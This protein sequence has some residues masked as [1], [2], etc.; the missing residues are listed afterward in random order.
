VWLFSHGTFDTYK[1]QHRGCGLSRPHHPSYRLTNRFN[2]QLNTESG[3]TKYQNL[4]F[5]DDTTSWNYEVVSE[6]DA[7]FGVADSD[8][9]SLEHFFSRPIKITSLTWAVGSDLFYDFNPWTLYFSNPR[10]INRISNFHLLRCNLKVKFVINGNGFYFGRAIASYWPLRDM[11]NLTTNRNFFPIDIIGASQRPHVYID[12]ATSQGGVLKLPFCWYRNALSIPLQE[13]ERMGLMNLRSM[14]PLRHANSGTESISVSVFVWAEDVNLSIPTANEPGALVPQMGEQD[15]Y[16]TGPIS[17]PAGVI[18]RYAGML[19]NIPPIA[20][21]ARATQMAASTVSNI[22]QMFGYSR[23]AILSDI[24]PYRPT[25]VGNMANTNVP[26]SVTKLTLDAK[27]ELTVDPRVAGLGSADEMPILSIAMRETFL[28]SFEWPIAAAS[29]TLLWN[30]EV[31]P[32]LWAES[33]PEYHFPACAFATLP[34]K[35]WRGSMK[36][37][38][39]IVAS[40]YHRGR[41]KMTYDPSYPLTNEYNTNYTHVVDVSQDKDFTITVGWGATRSMLSYRVPYLSAIPYGTSALGGAPDEFGN[42]IVSV[43][44]VNELSTP[45]TNTDAVNVNVFVSMGEDFEVFEPSVDILQNAY[46]LPPSDEELLRQSQ[47]KN[48]FVEQM[49]EIPLTENSPPMDTSSVVTKAPTL[50]TA[51]ATLSVYF[52]DP[53]TSFRQC[54]KRYNYHSQW[55]PDTIGQVAY[56][57]SM[58]NFPLFRGY[59]SQGVWQTSTAERFNYVQTTL[60]NYVSTAYVVRRGGLRWKHVRIGGD[61]CVNDIF[62]AIR[63]DCGC[64]GNFTSITLD[65]PGAA[66]WDA[67][68]RQL[69][70]FLT[71]TWSG[72]HSTVVRNNATLEIELPWYY[73]DRFFPSKDVTSS[74]FSHRLEGTWKIPADSAPFIQSFVAIGEDFSLSFFTGAPRMYFLSPEFDPAAA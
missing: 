18:S 43:Y 59:N 5:S 71:H 1:E 27:Q 57:F 63:E 10:V 13:W 58:P 41:M 6:P 72:A 23:P 54:L 42:G 2:I 51:D 53:I 17:R 60:L 68:T 33:P 14:Q 69:N 4:T 31:S 67:R 66:T 15:E 16:G 50:S 30:S 46:F 20:P 70:A 47:L 45:S 3:D 24:Q 52:G 73:N 64:V 37:R 36:F 12:P 19:T 56:K 38:F 28:T 40:A 25:L 44:V 9:A 29:E 35:F 61:C 62:T 32:V 26:D 65:T 49:G 34:F 7:T 39:Q 22:A 21:Y 8:D 48:R 55:C 74:A 11:D